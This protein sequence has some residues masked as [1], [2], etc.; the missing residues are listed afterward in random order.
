MKF[1]SLNNENSLT[2]KCKIFGCQDKEMPLTWY[3][4]GEKHGVKFGKYTAT[5]T[6]TISS[7]RG[8]YWCHNFRKIMGPEI[9][10][11]PKWKCYCEICEPID[12]EK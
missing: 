4:S 11:W 12:K 7:F 9:E 8:C 1:P 3:D 5:K 2:P 10:D 6:Y